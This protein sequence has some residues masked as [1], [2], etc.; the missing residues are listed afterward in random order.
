MSRLIWVPQYP[1]VMRYQE[2]WYTEFPKEFSNYFDDVIV[3]GD[4]YLKSL[5][6]SKFKQSTS[7]MFAPVEDAI[8]FELHQ[9][10]EYMNIPIY[11]EDVVFLSDLSFPGLFSNILYH[12][13]PN[14]CF[15]FSHAGPTNH[16]DYFSGDRISKHWNEQAISQIFDLIFVGSEHQKILMDIKNSVVVRL[17]YP[18]PITPMKVEKQYDVVSV[19]RLNDQ[20]I[21]LSD[22][23]KIEDKYG[24]IRKQFD[25]WDE[26][27]KF[28]SAS[29]ILIISSLADTFNYTILDAIKCG[30]I[31]IAPNRLCFPEILPK[32]YLYNNGDEALKLVDH[33][34]EG[35]LEVPRCL[36]EKEVFEFYKNVTEYMR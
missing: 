1:S 23:E 5:E 15:A 10:R 29:K 33:I 35:K 11:P 17:P 30:C 8:N 4:E 26:Y 25:T 28:L 32:E 2:W 19:C 18:V 24:I 9:I 14:R 13:R 20:K 27:S 31:P 3:L 7:E 34:L 22:E 6:T 21:C 36:C 12:E 16:L